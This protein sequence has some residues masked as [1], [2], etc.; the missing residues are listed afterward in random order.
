MTFFTSRKWEI[1]YMLTKKVIHTHFFEIFFNI[2]AGRLYLDWPTVL[3]VSGLGCLAPQWIPELERIEPGEQLQQVLLQK[4][5]DTEL[6]FLARAWYPLAFIRQVRF[7]SNTHE[8]CFG[9]ALLSVRIRIQ[10]QGFDQQN[11]KEKYS[12]KKTYCMDGHLLKGY[13]LIYYPVLQFMTR[14]TED[15]TVTTQ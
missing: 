10:I 12:W 5:L 15:I 2:Q 6:S 8:Q 1:K 3:E 13:F 9:S 14:F 7:A 11:L 4:G